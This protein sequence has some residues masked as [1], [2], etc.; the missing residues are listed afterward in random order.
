MIG[1]NDL[2]NAMGKV[3]DDYTKEMITQDNKIISLVLGRNKYDYIDKYLFSLPLPY[4]KRCN[5]CDCDCDG[6]YGIGIYWRKFIK[7]GTKKVKNPYYVPP[8]KRKEIRIAKHGN[9]FSIPNV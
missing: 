5:G 4:L 3:L 8:K 7:T 2:A 6:I 1:L 9:I